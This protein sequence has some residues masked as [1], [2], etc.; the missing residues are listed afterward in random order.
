MTFD[1]VAYIN[2]ELVPITQALCSLAEQEEQPDQQRFFESIL[3]G[4]E[5]T[6]QGAD[7]A[8]PFMQLSMSAFMGFE[9]SAPVAF[10]LDQLLAK[11]Q[12][13]SELMSLDESEI[14]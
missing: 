12:P 11:A 4:L 3:A 6:A 9:F 13:L 8:D 14:N 5:R 2:E 1:P 7:L 10:L